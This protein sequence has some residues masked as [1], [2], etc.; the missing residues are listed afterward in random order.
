MSLQLVAQL[1]WLGIYC[2]CI[3]IF[4]A[5]QWDVICCQHFLS[6]KSPGGTDMVMR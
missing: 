2:K 4:R 5:D 3:S 6:F 1:A